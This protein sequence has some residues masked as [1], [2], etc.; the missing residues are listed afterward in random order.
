MLGIVLIRC[1]HADL[2]LNVFGRERVTLAVGIDNILS[3]ALPL[4]GDAGI[5]Y[6]VLIL[7]IGCERFFDLGCT[8]DRNRAFVVD[9]RLRRLRIRRWIVRIVQNLYGKFFEIRTT[10]TVIRGNAYFQRRFSRKVNVLPGLEP[11]RAVGGDFKALVTQ[12]VRVAIA[13]ISIHSIQYTNSS[14]IHTFHQRVVG[15]SNVRRRVV[16]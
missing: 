16:G 13:H 11:Q 9:R 12:F 10:V 8:A 2:M 14:A 6:P 1:P 4:I 15:Q 3:V 7:Y 5:R